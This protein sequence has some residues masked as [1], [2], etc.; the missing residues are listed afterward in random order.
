MTGPLGVGGF[1][2]R[3]SPAERRDFFDIRRQLTELYVLV[4]ELGG[5][6]NILGRVANEAALPSTGNSPGDAWITD[7]PLDHLW[8][9]GGEPPSWVDT[10]LFNASSHA[11]LSGVTASQHHVRYSDAEAIAAIG[12]V[13]SLPPG[14]TIEQALTKIDATDY[15]VRWSTVSGG[16][17]VGPHVL[18]GAAGAPP[19]ELEEGQ[20]LYDPAIATQDQLHVL[21]GDSTA[22]P[23]ELVVGQLLYDENFTG[24]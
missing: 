19:A 8:A 7:D 17:V 2:P 18:E 21:E 4:G 12:D 3:T 20:L 1:E 24:V 13:N 22:P 11:A 16:G 6:L 9:W 10:G 5:G 23:A 15:N 14:G